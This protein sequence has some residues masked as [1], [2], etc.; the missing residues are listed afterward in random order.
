MVQ[1]VLV[2]SQKTCSSGWHRWLVFSNLFGTES[3]LLAVPTNWVPVSAEPPMVFADFV[4]ISF[5][6]LVIEEGLCP[7]TVGVY[8]SGVRDYFKMRTETSPFGWI[9]RGFLLHA[10]R[11]SPRP[12]NFVIRCLV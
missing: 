4:V 1:C 2:S 12:V 5:T 6:H 7:G 9:R 8:L 10:L 11:N 3:Y